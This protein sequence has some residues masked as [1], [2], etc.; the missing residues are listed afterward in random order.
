[1]MMCGYMIQ[2]SNYDNH[3]ISSTKSISGEEQLGKKERA[4]LQ[5]TQL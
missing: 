3:S 5:F 1:M 4:T 2:V